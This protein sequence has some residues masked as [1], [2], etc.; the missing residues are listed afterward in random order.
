MVLIVSIL[1]SVSTA[2]VGP[3][4]FLGLLVVNLAREFLKTF[5]HKYIFIGS[6][7]ISIVALVGGQL[8]IERILNFGTPISVVINLIGGI[9][10]LYLLLKEN[11]A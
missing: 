5:E 4:T 9:Y 10:F 7:L 2:L 8:L 6:A 1:V 11:V 3:I